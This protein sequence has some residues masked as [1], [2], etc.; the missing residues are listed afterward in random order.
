MKAKKFYWKRQIFFQKRRN[1]LRYP[2]CHPLIMLFLFLF[3][4]FFG[5][6]I[7]ILWVL[8]I[9]NVHVQLWVTVVSLVNC[10]ISC[11]VTFII[12]DLS[13]LIY[14]TFQC[15]RVEIL[16]FKFPLLFRIL[17]LLPSVEPLNIHLQILSIFNFYCNI[18]AEI[19]SCKHTFIM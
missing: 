3:F 18:L 15:S 2:L 17:C 12:F 8:V 5:Y 9:L 13:F 11:L 14:R 6:F 19:L 1:V 16:C 4:N 7:G 10:L